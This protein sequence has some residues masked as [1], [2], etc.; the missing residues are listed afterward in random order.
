MLE[1]IKAAR[2]GFLGFR[3]KIRNLS[4]WR[5]LLVI[6]LV[7]AVPAGIALASILLVAWNR[8]QKE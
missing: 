2:Q 6:L 3:E 4:R 1:R 7:V 8:R 5:K